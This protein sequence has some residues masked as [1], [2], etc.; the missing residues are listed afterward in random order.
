M[1]TQEPVQV[2]DNG[3]KLG[4]I[5]ERGSIVNIASALGLVGCKMFSPYGQP[6]HVG[7]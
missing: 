4:I 3:P 2:R 7:P 5:K 6:L 1:L